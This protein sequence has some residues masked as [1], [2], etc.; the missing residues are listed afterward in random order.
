[1][2]APA[3]EKTLT[4]EQES[5]QKLRDFYLGPLSLYGILLFCLFGFLDYFFHPEIYNHLLYLRMV[6]VAAIV[7]AQVVIRK[8]Q[9]VDFTVLRKLICF[10]GITNSLALF[11]MTWLI[12]DINSVYWVGLVMLVTIVGLIPA[13]TFKYTLSILASAVLPFTVYSLIKLLSTNDLHFLLGPIFLNGTAVLSIVGR[14]HLSQLEISEYSVRTQ[15]AS[16]IEN[17]DRIIDIKT[18]EGLRLKTLSKQFSPQI[19]EGIENGTIKLDGSIQRK[20]IC[21]LFIDIKDSTKKV[22]VL[23]PEVLEKILSLYMKDVVE[24]MLKKDMTIDKFLGDGVFGFTNSPIDQADYLERAVEVALGIQEHFILHQKT[25][26]DLWQGPFEYRMG[27]ASGVASIGFYGDDKYMRSYTA[28]GKVINLASR[29]NGAAETNEIVVTGEIIDGLK[30]RNSPLLDQLRLS[31]KPTQ[32][33]KGFES[34]I[35]EIWKIERV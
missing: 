30:K 15:L 31:Q 8:F 2:R 34:N 28:I 24:I 4:L 35:L 27:I 3:M 11:T 10:V 32:V 25:Y 33:L 20:E 16:E 18:T 14:W 13:M 17:R 1:M 9:V 7:F 6:A 22:S 5:A 21:A 12:D 26:E 29:L 19:V 23:A